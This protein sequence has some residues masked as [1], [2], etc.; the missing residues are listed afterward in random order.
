MKWI[1]SK[2]ENMSNKSKPRNRFEKIVKSNLASKT[3]GAVS[4]PSAPVKAQSSNPIQAKITVIA[5]EVAQLKASR[6][7]LEEVLEA[8]KAR[9]AHLQGM[10]EAYASI[11]IQP[12]QEKVQ[13]GT[14]GAAR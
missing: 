7:K 5:T 13:D 12:A 11:R 9:I 14:H 2:K 4:A 6:V 1:L 8:T 10:V 3:N